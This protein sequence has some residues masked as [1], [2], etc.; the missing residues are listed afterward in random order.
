M[1]VDELGTVATT[2]RDIEVEKNSSTLDAL[3]ESLSLLWA[4]QPAA[5]SEFERNP[6]INVLNQGENSQS[7][8]LSIDPNYKPMFKK[9]FVP[10]TS[11]ISFFLTIYE[12]AM[13]KTTDELKKEP[14]LNCLHPTCQEVV[15]PEIPS[16][17]TW[18]DM[19]QLL[20]EEFGGDLILEVKKDAFMNIAFKPKETL[21]KFADLFYIEGQKLITSCQLAPRE[22][23]TA[24]YNALKVNQLLCLHVKVHKACLT[25]MKSIKTLL[26]DM[27]LAHRGTMFLKNK[28]IS[29]CTTVEAAGLICQQGSKQAGLRPAIQLSDHLKPD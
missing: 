24:C 26:Q 3:E 6:H 10:K 14:I 11:T 17:V 5:E 8:S 29:A 18:E 4:I 28:T 25:S 19:K 2:T 15:V 1:Q 21:A 22:G 23:Y 13:K 9:I 7:T 20:I 16:I 12:T 27:R